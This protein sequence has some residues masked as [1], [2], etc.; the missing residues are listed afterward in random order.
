MVTEQANF[1]YLLE[2]PHLGPLSHSEKGTFLH[3]GIWYSLRSDITF[4]GAK[5]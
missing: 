4:V 1:Y 3:A 5:T 2:K